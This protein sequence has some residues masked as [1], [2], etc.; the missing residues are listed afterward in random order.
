M[1]SFF[2]RK[3]RTIKTEH[4]PDHIAF[5]MDGNGRW[6]RRR[7]LPRSV[8]HREGSYTLRRIAKECSKIGIKYL[9]VFA[10]STENKR[11]VAWYKVENGLYYT[12]YYHVNEKSELELLEREVEDVRPK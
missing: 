2:L 4:L 3:N 10:L 5:I 1:S 7:G 12:D 8:G 11:L 9:S 6:A